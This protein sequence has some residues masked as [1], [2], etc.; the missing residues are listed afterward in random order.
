M[1]TDRLMEWVTDPETGISSP[2][3][4]TYS[5]IIEKDIINVD[6]E[7]LENLRKQELGLN[8]N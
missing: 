5:E 7:Y 3:W 8:G 1:S 6:P 2:R 4:F